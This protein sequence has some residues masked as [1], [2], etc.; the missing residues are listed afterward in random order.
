MVFD[1]FKTNEKISEKFT[2]RVTKEEYLIVKKTAKRD[3]V[4]LNS[5]VRKAIR[6]IK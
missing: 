5:V 6:Q 4:S 1:F 2:I 3:C